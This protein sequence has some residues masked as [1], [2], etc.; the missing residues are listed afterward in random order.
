MPRRYPHQLN[1]D[2]DQVSGS[3]QRAIRLPNDGVDWPGWAC[4]SGDAGTDRADWAW[5]GV[6]GYRECGEGGV[7][8]ESSENRWCLAVVERLERVN[9]AIRKEEGVLWR[10][11]EE[12]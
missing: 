8:S 5:L 11:R 4:P 2:S 3:S 1:S 9:V 12:W 6:R 10:A 7:T